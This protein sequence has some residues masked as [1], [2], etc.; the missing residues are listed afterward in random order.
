MQ[1]IE[2]QRRGE[3]VVVPGSGRGGEAVQAKYAM[4]GFDRF[5]A[6]TVVEGSF[7]GPARVLGYTGQNA[8]FSWER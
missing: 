5:K 3:N 2:N 6:H 4:D 8:A 1:Q 7:P